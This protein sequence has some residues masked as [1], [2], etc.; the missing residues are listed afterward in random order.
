MDAS[1][2]YP[3]TYRP[4]EPPPL[5]SH[6]NSPVVTFNPYYSPSHLLH[7][8][9]PPQSPNLHTTKFCAPYMYTPPFTL[10][11][12][13]TL[14]T[15]QPDYTLES[16]V[17]VTATTTIVDSPKRMDNP[18]DA[19]IDKEN[20]WEDKLTQLIA[21]IEKMQDD[22]TDKSKLVDKK[23]QGKSLVVDE[24]TLQRQS[25]DNSTKLVSPLPQN[26]SDSSDVVIGDGSK[27][28]EEAVV[29]QKGVVVDVVNVEPQVFVKNPLR[30]SDSVVES[31]SADDLSNALDVSNNAS[32]EAVIRSESSCNILA[33]NFDDSFMMD[34]LL[35]HQNSS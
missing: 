3:V 35:I 21:I 17:P 23:F 4:P 8:A 24:S 22:F 11:C 1:P 7:D 33:N 29:V 18:N 28:V 16:T 6:G 10:P 26:S 30:K 20:Q 14:S 5:S 13:T 19:S 15:N 32:S 34:N 31:V 2:Y 25:E 27:L 9:E 12:Q